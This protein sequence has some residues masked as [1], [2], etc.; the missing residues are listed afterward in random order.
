MLS[1]GAS[2]NNRNKLGFVV[3]LLVFHS[4]VFSRRHW[5]LLTR[6]VTVLIVKRDSINANRAET[7][8]ILRTKSTKKESNELEA[9]HNPI[10]K[11]NSAV[12]SP[13]PRKQVLQFTYR[14]DSTAVSSVA[15]VHSPLHFPLDRL[16]ISPITSP[17]NIAAS[18]TLNIRSSQLEELRSQVLDC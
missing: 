10:D 14:K 11:T 2:A 3:V 13:F 8:E 15:F 6:L 16:P 1:V 18:A 4:E 7:V 5:A 9:Q 17:S 12:E